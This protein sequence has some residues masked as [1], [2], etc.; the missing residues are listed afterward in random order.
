VADL[1][2]WLAASVRGWNADPTP[3]EWGGKRATRRQRAR[4]RQRQRHALGGSGGYTRRL[5]V[6]DPTA[7]ARN[8][9]QHDK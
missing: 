9:Y 2:A 7:S 8:G 6:G 4:E 1:L 3:F 5:S